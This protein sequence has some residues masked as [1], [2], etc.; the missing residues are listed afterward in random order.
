MQRFLRNFQR[1]SSD[2]CKDLQ[3]INE[4]F[5]CDFYRD[6]CKD[7]CTSLDKFFNVFGALLRDVGGVF[8]G[9]FQGFLMDFRGIFPRFFKTIFKDFC[10]DFQ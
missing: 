5:L 2:F 1:I 10:R 3:E 9:F 7:F 8:E 4:R 6:P